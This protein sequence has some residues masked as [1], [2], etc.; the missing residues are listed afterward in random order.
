MIQSLKA[1]HKIPPGTPFII[2][3]RFGAP[4]FEALVLKRHTAGGLILAPQGALNSERFFKCDGKSFQMDPKG[5]AL[6][7]QLGRVA[8][9]FE[10]NAPA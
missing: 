2:Y 1:L 7:T 3:E 9:R 5:F 4:Y 8:V 10:V 6:R